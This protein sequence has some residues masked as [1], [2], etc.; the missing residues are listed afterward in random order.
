[1]VSTSSAQTVKALPA[2]WERRRSLHASPWFLFA[3]A[4][5]LTAFGVLLH[6]L[7]RGTP[8]TRQFFDPVLPGMALGC[9]AVGAFIVSR[10][11]RNL[12]GWLLCSGVLLAV[13]FFAEQYAVYSV[14]VEPGSLPGGPAMAW[15]A[16][17]ISIPGYLAIWTLLPLL[18]PDGHPPSTAWRPLLWLSVGLIAGTTVL[19]A[20]AAESLGTAST[21]PILESEAMAGLAGN[22]RAAGVLVLAPLCVLGLVWRFR[23][24]QG[25]DRPRL[26]WP[27]RA[28]VVA[29]AV[30]PLAT[31]VSLVTGAPVPIGLYQLIGIAALLTVPAA[32]AISIVRHGLYDLDA[33]VDTLI[34]R[35]LVY[36]SL[37][38][39]GISV[40]L[41]VLLLLEA[42]ISGKHGFGLSLVALMVV[43][44]VAAGLR[45][46]LQ[47][48]VDRLLY[49]R[50]DYDY[51]V[52]AALS[53]SLRSSLGPDAV[54]PAI[55]ETVATGLK[56]P[57]V[58][59]TVGHGDEVTASASYGEARD[60]VVVMALG[61]QGEKVGQLMVAPRGT[62]ESFD[63]VDRRLLGYLA[64]QVG[65]AAYALCLTA[66]LQRSR[67]RLVTAREEERRR[68]RRDL[69]DGLQ[70]ALAGVT[71][72]IEAVRNIVGPESAAEQLLDRLKT[73]LET[74]GGDVRRLVYDL[75]PPALDVLGLVGALRQQADRF[76][77]SPGGLEV[78]VEAADDLHGLPAA[79][80]VAAFRICLEALENAR[81]HSKANTCVMSLAV[82]NGYLQLE[83]RDDGIGIPAAGGA[84]VGLVAMRE[85]AAELGG[86]LSVQSPAGSGALLRA[87][88]PLAQR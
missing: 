68:L 66:D 59:I 8:N 48:T 35:A 18:F 27:V 72:G 29:A 3:A 77:L 37:T 69:H 30:P 36:G 84:G 11:S 62:S 34:N 41:V 38:T 70:P 63:S 78:I 60:D 12:V 67:E 50:R 82:D 85:R 87:R 43:A 31:L 44:P 4:V 64:D 22:G 2:P 39:V 58:A 33:R 80:E 40:F 45:A 14:L 10:R 13:G 17:W 65:V 19:A 42:L 56:L 61:H 7:N 83:V 55:V 71:L 53:R 26:V 73:E 52:F 54:L 15:L 76:A 32:V 25:P 5:V 57:Y 88:L 79:V 23:R 1:M 16:S 6:V 49:K 46:Q 24:S 86:T 51:S 81:K 28:A 47:R 21:E 9:S 75:R 20:L 74:A